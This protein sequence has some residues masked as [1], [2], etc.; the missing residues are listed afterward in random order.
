MRER[1]DSIE[2]LIQQEVGRGA[3]GLF[4][5]SRGGLWAAA[6][7]FSTAQP[8]YV[9]ILTGFFVPRGTPPAAETDGPA[10]AAL[11]ALGLS[12]IG[13][14]CRLLTDDACRSA[15]EAALLG[16]GLPGVSIDAVVPDAPLQPVIE[17]WRTLGV[18]WMIAIERCGL[19]ADGHPRN[20]RGEDLSPYTAPLDRVFTVGPWRTIAIGDG[21][22]EIGMG[23]LPDGLVAREVPLGATIACVTPADFLVTAGVSHWGAYGLLAGLAVCRADWRE[24]LL[25]CLDPAI[26]RRILETLVQRGP[27]VDGVTLRQ[28]PTIDGLDLATQ[29][30]KLERIRA[31]ARGI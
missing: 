10:G 5:A 19:S 25:D 1:I 15:C 27:A 6:S 26:D 23:V 22:N 21:G 24:T 16:A 20:M 31:I 4:A 18:D 13:V 8:R 14:P 7:A 12:R 29:H 3:T 2:T 17:A 9:G 11:L 30:A 28:A